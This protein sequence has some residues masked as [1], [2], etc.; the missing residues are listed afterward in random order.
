VSF[1]VNNKTYKG[2]ARIVDKIKEPILA[3][4]VS[5]LM[6]SKYGWNDGLIVELTSKD[7]KL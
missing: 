3:K 4:A 2:Y 7:N 1:K 5:D 6:F